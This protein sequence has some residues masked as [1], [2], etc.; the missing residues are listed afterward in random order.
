MVGSDVLAYAQRA[1]V[2]SRQS[3]VRAGRVLVATV[4]S[5]SLLVGCSKVMNDYDPTGGASKKDYESLENRRPVAEKAAEEPPIP[6]LQSMLAM[7]TAPELADTRRVSIAVTETTPLRDIFIAARHAAKCTF[8]LATNLNTECN[9]TNA[10]A[11][12]AG[13]PLL[14]LRV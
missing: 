4:A 2:G 1:W 14:P 8:R 12:V 6:Q 5:A 11:L 10:L 9:K 13:G 3:R 7:P